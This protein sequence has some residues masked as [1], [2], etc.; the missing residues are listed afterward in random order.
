MVYLFTAIGFIFGFS[1]G[2]GTINVMLR[3]KTKE[4]IQSD[5]S[6]RTKYGLLVWGFAAIGGWIGYH[7][8]QNYFY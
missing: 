1:V 2:L 8:F 5:R 3:H 4:E 7:V 6:I